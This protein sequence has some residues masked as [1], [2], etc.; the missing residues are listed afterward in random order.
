MALHL[1]AHPLVWVLVPA[2]E[3][4]LAL[5]PL[6]PLLPRGCQGY[7]HQPT[8]AVGTQQQSLA[9]DGNMVVVVVVVVVA[10]RLC[11]C[12]CVP[13]SDRR[14]VMDRCVSLP[15]LNTTPVHSKRNSSRLP[16]LSDHDEDDRYVTR[17]AFH[18][19]CAY[20]VV[21][22]PFATSRCSYSSDSDSSAYSTDFD[23]DADDERE[24]MHAWVVLLFLCGSS[25]DSCL[26]HPLAATS[27]TKGSQ[28]LLTI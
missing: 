10:H 7:P 27:G 2:W 15:V 4:V 19:R 28:R 3:P 25:P 26:C 12:A 6:L 22:H 8:A 1:Q 24:C 23:D 21:S 14:G 20:L 18:L 16:R 17:R 9:A 11:A 5:Q 13:R